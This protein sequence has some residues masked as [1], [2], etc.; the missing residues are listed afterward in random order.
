[1]PLVKF[2]LFSV[3]EHDMIPD[4]LLE[5]ES[6]YKFGRVE[7]EELSQDIIDHLNEMKPLVFSQMMNMH[8]FCTLDC[9]QRLNVFNVEMEIIENKTEEQDWLQSINGIFEYE[10]SRE[11]N[12]I[13]DNLITT[14]KLDQ[15]LKILGPENISRWMRS[16]ISSDGVD[17]D[18]MREYIDMA[19]KTNRLDIL[20]VLFEDVYVAFLASAN[21]IMV[22]RYML[23]NKIFSD[24]ELEYLSHNSWHMSEDVFKYYVEYLEERPTLLSKL[25][26][27]TCDHF[28]H[29]KDTDKLYLRIEYMLNRGVNPTLEA[30]HS[31]LNHEALCSLIK[32]CKKCNPLLRDILYSEETYTCLTLS[33]VNYSP[34]WHEHKK[35]N[36][37]LNNY[38]KTETTVPCGRGQKRLYSITFVVHEID[39][40]K[41]YINRNYLFTMNED[42]TLEM[43]HKFVQDNIVELEFSYK[44]IIPYT[45]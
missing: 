29:R 36:V 15:C 2:I 12:V 24:R 9:M 32:E 5:M 43:K 22:M 42:G 10:V 39:D 18:Q 6:G 3:Y 34:C 44:N 27:D 25:L 7:Y 45:S 8:A 33:S 28:I 20:D 35:F 21:N 26:L 31:A 30:L 13:Y 1:M 19:R 16:W 40:V 4:E 38:R 23:K 11:E 41:Y 14:G 37:I 17:G